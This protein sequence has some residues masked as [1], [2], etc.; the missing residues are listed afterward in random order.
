M[1]F[2]ARRLP[3]L[4]SFALLFLLLPP[5]LPAQ[6]RPFDVDA[7]LR[8]QRLSDPQISPDGKTVAF[9][10]SVPDVAANKGAKSVCG[11]NVLHFDLPTIFVRS[12]LLDVAPSRQFDLK[13]WGTDA[14]DLM[15]K[16]FPTSGAMK[17][18]TIAAC[19][20]ISIP[21]GDID[22]S[23]VEEL[24]KNDPKKLGEYVRSDVDLVKALHQRYSGFFC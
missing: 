2:S 9:A 16:R 17:M 22:G 19:M 4:P 1:R 20:G 23:Q 12:I 15:K 3:A 14:I 24:W 8:I 18:K 13:P 11:Y 10:V 7:L 21:A 5:V 6:K